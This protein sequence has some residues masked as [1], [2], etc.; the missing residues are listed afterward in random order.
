M[1]ILENATGQCEL[2]GCVLGLELREESKK[3]DYLPPTQASE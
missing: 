2:K 3:T 1:K